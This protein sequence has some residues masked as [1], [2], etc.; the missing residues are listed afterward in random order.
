MFTPTGLL[1]YHR[2]K[3]RVFF[4]RQAYVFT[5]RPGLVAKNPRPRTTDDLS[6]LVLRE[7]PPKK[8][9]PEIPQLDTRPVIMGVR[10][11][12]EPDSQYL[13]DL[14]G[15][16]QQ[17]IRQSRRSVHHKMTIADE[18]QSINAQRGEK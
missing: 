15:L 16:I 13:L 6:T 9:I 14:G 3:P 1:L 5:F 2:R 12:R 17:P 18:R 4:Q 7:A 11:Q 10:Y 8:V